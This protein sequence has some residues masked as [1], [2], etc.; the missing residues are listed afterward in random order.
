MLG[1]TAI[2][3]DLA[4]MPQDQTEH[5]YCQHLLHHFNAQLSGSVSDSGAGTFPLL[6]HRTT[7]ILGKKMQYNHILTEMPYGL[8]VQQSTIQI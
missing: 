8:I 1:P 4:A 3:S 6:C 5:L 7:F 2:R